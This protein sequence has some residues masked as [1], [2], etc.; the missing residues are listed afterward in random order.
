MSTKKHLKTQEQQLSRITLND[1]LTLL[2]FS[3]AF[4]AIITSAPPPP[5]PPP[6]PP[7]DFHFT[8]NIACY[9]SLEAMITTATKATIIMARRFGKSSNDNM[10]DPFL[11]EVNHFHDGGRY[12]IAPQINGRVSI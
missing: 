10:T 8:N 4:A 7:H 11:P 1:H 5:P 2:P 12:H 6:P 9:S 3:L